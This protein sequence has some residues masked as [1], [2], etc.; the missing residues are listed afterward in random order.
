MFAIVGP[1]T[2]DLFVSGLSRLPALGGDEFTASS[3]VFCQE[4]LAMVL[5]GNGGNTAYVLATLGAPAALYSAGGRDILSDV[6]VGWMAAR[7]VNLDGFVR[8][9]SCAIATTTVV[10]DESLNRLAFHHP[11]ALRDFS[12]A[13]TLTDRFETASV[14]LI[15]GYTLL[16]TV[17]AEGFAGY[18]AHAHQAGVLTAV[19]FGPA[20]GEPVR[21]AELLP[22]LPDVDYVISNAH[23][24]STCTGADDLDVGAA[25]LLEAGARCLVVKRGKQG[26]VVRSP[27]VN[28][29]VPGLAVEARFTVGAGDSF[30][31][32][33]LY[34]IQQGLDVKRAVRFGNAVAALTVSS[35]HGVLGCPN[36]EQVQTLLS[37]AENHTH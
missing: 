4:P 14:L 8:N 24:L 32:G 17:R 13:D 23:E 15:S 6:A 34:G 7:G 20:V 2:V 35:S 22:L 37:E 10:T 9:P 21:L 27:G 1:T 29:D 5:G 31:A 11:G 19:D 18:L 25:K 28:V 33:L 30:N 12:L 3:L 16:P 26:A 36:L